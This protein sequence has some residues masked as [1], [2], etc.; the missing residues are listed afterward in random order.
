MPRSIVRVLQV[1]GVA[2]VAAMAGACSSPSSSQAATPVA[3]SNATLFEGARLIVGDDNPPIENSAFLVED[4]PEKVPE[5]PFADHLLA[6]KDDA[7]VVLHVDRLVA[8]HLLVERIEE[9]LSRGRARKG[10]PMEERPAE[11]AE[12]VADMEARRIL[13]PTDKW[14]LETTRANLAAARGE[15]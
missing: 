13:A 14:M 12:R 8:S 9:L 4:Q 10:S 11:A 7:A 15:P 3:T 2:V 1:F 5:L 6:A